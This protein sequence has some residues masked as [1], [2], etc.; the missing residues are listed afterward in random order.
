MFKESLKGLYFNLHRLLR[1][2]ARLLRRIRQ[3]NLLV[4]L[5]L[6]KISPQTNPFWQP[7]HPELFDDLLFFLKRHFRVALFRELKLISEDKADKDKPVVV[8]SFDDGYYDFIEYAAPLLEKHSLKANMNVIPAG[9][10]SGFPPW[11]IQLYDFLNSVP[12]SLINEVRLPGFDAKLK[13]EDFGSKVAYGLQISRFL[14]N[15]PHREREEFW[16]IIQSYMKKADF[17]TTRMMMAEEIKSIAGRHEIGAHSFSHESMGFEENSFFEEDLRNCFA[18][19]QE[20][21]RLPMEIYAFPNG[22]YRQEQIDTLQVEGIEHILLVDENYSNAARSVHP[23]FTI[24]GSSKAE[25]R[26][27]SLGFNSKGVS[28]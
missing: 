2:D 13:G 14:K 10:E 11:N 4:V 15:R 16:E 22:S 18:Y 8:L 21:L 27:Q 26:F 6:H 9:S 20:T 25:N 24:Y 19:F 1:R 5:S 28:T 12:R 23:R 3:E 17:K 7:L